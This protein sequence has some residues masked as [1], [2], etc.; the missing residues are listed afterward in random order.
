M[1][2]GCVAALSGLGLLLATIGLYGAI[3]YSVSERKKELGI[4]VALG[5]QP[6]QLLKM[7]LRQTLVIAGTGVAVGILLGVGVTMLVR[8]QF[9]EIG[10]VEWSVLVPIGV[11]ML[12]VSLLVAYLS[13]RPWITINPMEA[14]RHA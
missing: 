11:A 7:I 4:R 12:A 1:T 9:Y 14:V 8:S 13:A 2:A 5:A 10:A 6:R 3:S